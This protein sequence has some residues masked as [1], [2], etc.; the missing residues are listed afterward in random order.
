[1]WSESFGSAIEGDYLEGD[2]QLDCALDLMRRLPPQQ[3]ERNLNDLIDLCPR[4]VDDLLSAV[5]QP[6]KIARDKETGKEYLLC[7]YNR[8]SDSYR[9][10]RFYITFQIHFDACFGAF[11]TV[12]TFISSSP[13][14]NTYDPPLEDGASPSDKLRKLEI[15]MNAAFEAYRDAYFEGGVSSVY[16]WDL[17]YGFAGVVLIKKIGDGLRNI[18]G[19][20]DSIHVIEI[21]EK[22][23]GRHA[24]YKLTSTV[25][26]WL[27]M[28]KQASGMMNLGGSVTRQVEAD[29]PVND[30]TNT[31]LINI[32][33]MIEDM[34]SKIRST[35]N[36]VYFGKTKQ[37]VGELRTTLDAEELKRQKKIATEIK[38]GIGK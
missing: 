17:D 20:W 7:D 15:E 34:E 11:Y 4:L 32:G 29:H 12:F 8:D 35:L 31:H 9:L 6:L 30:S 2:Q 18:Q 23:G 27:Q 38:G 3:V 14:S 36:E 5:D 13:W 28:T 1:M 26:L 21:Q 16:F 24:H 10:T 22:A 37:I 19:C 33:K 25:M